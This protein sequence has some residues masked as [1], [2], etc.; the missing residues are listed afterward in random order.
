MPDPSQMSCLFTGTLPDTSLMPYTLLIP[1]TC[2][3]TS[4]QL[5]PPP[6]SRNKLR[7]ARKNK[8]KE[9]AERFSILDAE[10]RDEFLEGESLF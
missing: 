6:I 7:K 9:F 4:V 1:D 8:R 5:S 2:L 10:M 3:M